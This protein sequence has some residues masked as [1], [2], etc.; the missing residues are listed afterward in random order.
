MQRYVSNP[1][2]RAIAPVGEYHRSDRAKPRHLA[3]R[4]PRW[5]K[6]GSFS[7]A[8]GRWSGLPF[9]IDP[10][11]LMSITEQVATH[12]GDAVIR[13]EIRADGSET[14]MCFSGYLQVKPD[15]RAA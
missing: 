10:D 7:C 11:F 1:P 9:E 14:R 13:V 5:I 12:D 8:T 2:S 15:P 6:S 4:K 3:S